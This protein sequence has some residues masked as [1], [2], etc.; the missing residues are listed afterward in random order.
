MK[1]GYIF[2]LDAL[3]GAA[4]LFL[5]VM[6]IS[7][8]YIP[9]PPQ[10]PSYS[11]QDIV[12]IFSTMTISEVNNQYA[13][14]LIQSGLVVNLNNTLL[15]QIGEL[16]VLGHQAEAKALAANL[17]YQL[18][19]DTYGIGFYIDES[20]AYEKI[21]GNYTTLATSKALISGIE[22]GKPVYGFAS[23]A[24]VATALNRTTA[25]YAYF[26]GFVGSG[27]I[28]HRILM[29]QNF[30]VNKLVLE[31]AMGG[32]LSLY[33]NDAFCG[34][35]TKSG[36]VNYFTISQCLDKFAG[37]WN[38]FSLNFSVPQK[39]SYIGGG[40]FKVDYSSSEVV[41]DYTYINGQV[42]KTDYLPE[43]RGAINVYSSESASGNITGMDVLL[44]FNTN[45]GMFMSIGNAT[46]YDGNKTGQVGELTVFLNN[47]MLSEMLDNY[48]GLG[49]T[50][51]IR[52]G[53]FATNITNATGNVTDV[54]VTTSR[55]GTM[56]LADINGTNLTRMEAAK[57]LDQLFTNI[58]LSSVGNR[59]GLVSFWAS[60]HTD[61]QISSNATVLNNTI[62]DYEV[63]NPQQAQR[64]LCR[65]VSDA[66]SML[67]Q[68]L[69]KK[70]VLLM[71]DGN[72]TKC[73]SSGSCT[74]Q[75]ARDDVIA[76]ACNDYNTTNVTI[77]AVGFGEG[78]DNNLLSAVANC[79]NGKFRA[80]TNYSGLQDIYKDF[81]A[82]IGN[83][84]VAY[85]LQKVAAVGVASSLY[86]DSYVQINYTPYVPPVAFGQTLIAIETPRS[87]GSVALS[88]N[89]K[90]KITEARITSYS[91]DLWTKD[92]SV[93]NAGST[94]FY[95]LSTF[96]KKFELL[97]DPFV[98]EIPPPLILPGYNNV[99]VNT[100]DA[101]S[102][103]P[104]Q[105]NRIIYT[106]ALNIT[107]AGY[108]GV[109]QNAS[110]CIWALNFED[111]TN[112]S[113]K[114]PKDYNGT[115]ACYYANSSY[116]AADAVN[117]AAFSVLSQLDV[118]GDGL[119]DVNL[120]EQSLAIA[121]VKISKVPSLWG[122]AIAEVRLWQ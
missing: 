85:E 36:D 8:M 6:L 79:T 59:E 44:H 74:S 27:A 104:S 23:R 40:Y 10:S 53:H 90:I 111:G 117:S 67:S 19:A 70:Y 20:P 96:G 87:N 99:T 65:A 46:V 43:I 71:T 122:P 102:A 94:V 18:L 42:S 16:W 119:L 107:V 82:D 68:P 52:I 120:N 80:S 112:G 33:V 9:K 106:I 47:T 62:A 24:Y 115:E 15:E 17:S 63:Q 100:G 58:L 83:I 11:T 39:D 118:D 66:K 121:L 108:S 14:Q 109:F 97:G 88:I 61:S 78:A 26:G 54:V 34:N 89:N 95:N 30:T 49:L 56:G 57:Q 32:N 98:V 25:A 1:K 28:K 22:T 110:G 35:Y 86:S 116:N 4:L 45:Y 93:S 113:V 7:N 3:V 64:W 12:G 77:Y 41:Q 5:G 13:K 21:V 92:S 50:V 37:G 60:S 31:L 103:K 51:P 38:N 55:T 91:Q 69:R 75:K 105:D 81:A 2:S 101:N 73:C 29:P 72:T 76:A 114:I 48:S 84:S